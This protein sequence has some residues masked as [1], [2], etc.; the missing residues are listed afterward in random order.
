[1]N[2][3]QLELDNINQQLELLTYRKTQLDSIMSEYS[4]VVNRVKSLIDLMNDAMVEPS[5][6]LL[7]IEGIVYG[8]PEPQN[9]NNHTKINSYIIPFDPL[10]HG[11]PEPTPEE[12]PTELEPTEEPEPDTVEQEAKPSNPELV[13]LMALVPVATE[14]TPIK[15]Q[16][17]EKAWRRNDTL[18]IGFSN[19]RLMNQWKKWIKDNWGDSV[20]VWNDENLE[21]FSHCLSVLWY[22]SSR[23]IDWERLSNLNYSF[24]PDEQPTGISLDDVR[25]VIKNFQSNGVKFI[26]K[27][28]LLAH[29][30]NSLKASDLENYLEQLMNEGLIA[31]GNKSID[32]LPTKTQDKPD[33]PTFEYTEVDSKTTK[34]YNN[35]MLLGVAK[36]LGSHW[37]SPQFPGETFPNRR[38]V[39]SALW[40]LVNKF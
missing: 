18:L 20:K 2:S 22:G 5:N 7:E 25:E 24:K 15:T 27:G 6:L 32:L 35:G 36:N 34:I 21:G 33:N 19:K 1:M 29:H 23:L 11:E 30:L 10:I 31:L 17:N 38:D 12:Q 9:D 14:P 16:L 3:L 26:S 8:E 4:D 37:E 28:E 39:V 13:K 40:E